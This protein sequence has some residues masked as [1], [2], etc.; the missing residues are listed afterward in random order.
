MPDFIAYPL[1]GLAAAGLVALAMVW[2][3]GQGAQSPAPFG[4]PLAAYAPPLAAPALAKPAA[5]L[6]GRKDEDIAAKPARVRP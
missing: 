3:Q 2:P 1:I 4:R 5:V 6:R